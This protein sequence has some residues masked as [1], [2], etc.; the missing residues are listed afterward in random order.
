MTPRTRPARSGH[1]SGLN[2][3]RTRRALL[4]D[5]LYGAGLLAVGGAISACGDATDVG[6]NLQSNIP[7]VGPLGAADANGVRL[8]EGFSSRILAQSGQ[9]VAGTGY[10]WPGSPDGA[11]IFPQDDGGW[12][13]TVNSEIPTNAPPAGGA[14][15]IRFDADAGI[16]DAYRILGGT[17]FNCAGGPTPWGTWLSCEEDF[18]GH[19][20]VYE[21]DPTGRSQAVRLEAMGLFTHEAVAV[22]PEDGR[23]YMTEDQPD[24]G[25]YRYTPDRYPELGTGVLEI[26]RVHD[27]DAVQ[28]GEMS[29]VDWLVVPD[30]LATD[31]LTRHQLE[32]STGFLGGEGIWYRDGLVFFSTKFDNRIYRY[33]ARD[34]TICVLYH[35]ESD[36]G[37]LTGV[38]N[39][40]T[41]EVGGEVLVA[42]D[43]GDMQIVA[44]VPEGDG[45]DLGGVIPLVQIE[46]QDDS[47]VTGPV[48]DESGT[49]LYF[50][51]QRGQ[52]GDFFL[53]GIT[54]EVTGPFVVPA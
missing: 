26:A 44:L 34:D 14:S 20:A 49:R 22:D 15:A 40:T 19:G 45:C 23:L 54:Y 8:P 9:P 7:N 3:L 11:G 13:Y 5:G 12:I 16:V 50:S 17:N 51:S 21:C 29:G 10:V 18:A 53:S 28:A 31:E 47:E 52:G 37:V 27:L 24:G 42:E 41:S 30:P 46:G 2:L 25:F 48:F 4:R 6:T 38:D 1:E 43:G 32:E 33:D 35:A 36:G 39:V